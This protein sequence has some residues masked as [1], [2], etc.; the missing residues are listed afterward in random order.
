MVL[1]LEGIR[2]LDLTQWVFGPATAAVLGDWRAEILLEIGYTWE[3][4]TQF[5][6]DKIIM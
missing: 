4:I 1:S 5:K 3:D 6:D 2:V